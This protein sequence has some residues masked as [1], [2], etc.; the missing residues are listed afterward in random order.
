MR[1]LIAAQQKQRATTYIIYTTSYVRVHRRTSAAWVAGA[2]C[3]KERIKHC[4]EIEMPPFSQLTKLLTADNH[5]AWRWEKAALA[6]R[7]HNH[8]R[9]VDITGNWHLQDRR[10]R[11]RNVVAIDFVPKEVAHVS[12]SD[13]S[14]VLLDHHLARLAHDEQRLNHL[15]FAEWIALLRG[16]GFYSRLRAARKH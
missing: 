2:P 15:L 9:V 13:A 12:R 4:I 6:A 1:A 3:S 11:L 5:T 16:E 10:H 14:P 7:R 8:A